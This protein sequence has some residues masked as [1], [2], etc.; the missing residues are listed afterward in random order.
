MSKECVIVEH[1]DRVAVLRLNRGI[2]NAINYELVLELKHIFAQLV[3]NPQI[4]GLVLTSSNPKFFSIGLDI[5]GLFDL[6]QTEFKSFYH[7]YVQL[8]LDVMTFPKPVIG[9]IIGHAIAGGYILSLCC[10]YRFISGGR[11]LVGLNEVKL[12]L[13]VPFV[14]DCILRRMVGFRKARDIIDSGDFYIP[15][16]AL[17]LGLVDEVVPIDHLVQRSIEKIEELA[18]ASLHAY[19]LIKQNRVEPIEA[20]IES[21]LDSKQEDFITSW[22]SPEAR[23]LLEA[24]ISKF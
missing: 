17:R 16:D 18:S 11:K 24:A 6:P 20:E 9:A 7:S 22:Y 19:S 12:G 4:Q 15:D 14:A 8:C 5:P 23:A 3:D 10:D 13:P 1:Q 21:Q 2:T